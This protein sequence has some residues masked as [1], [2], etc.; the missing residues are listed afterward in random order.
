MFI[1]STGTFFIVN[2]VLPK[3]PCIL[4]PLCVLL[5]FLVPIEPSALWNF[6]PCHP[7]PP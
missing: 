7:G 5:G 3:C 6:E 2:F 1:S 4:F